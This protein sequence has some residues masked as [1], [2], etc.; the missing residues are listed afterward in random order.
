[1]G[2]PS[3]GDDPALGSRS[4]LRRRIITRS[5]AALG[6]PTYIAHRG[7]AVA[8][9]VR[10]GNKIPIVLLHS[11]S[12][13]SFPFAELIDALNGGGHA[14]IAVDFPGHG[15]SEDARDPGE[16]YSFPGYAAAV[17][18]V[19][20]VLG[21]VDCHLLGWSLGGHVAL[22]MMAASAKQGSAPWSDDGVLDQPPHVHGTLVCGTPPIRPSPEALIDAFSATPDM[23]F[24]GE[25]HLTPAQIDAYA[26]LLVAPCLSGDDMLRTMIAR[27]DGR[28][29]KN[30]MA[31]GLAGVGVDQVAALT[32]AP[33][34]VA[35]VHGAHDPFVCQQ[36]LN[37]LSG[38]FEDRVHVAAQAAHAPFIE[39][40]DL[41]LSLA[42]RYFAAAERR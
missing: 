19:L 2:A 13:S 40:P 35:V 41:F 29:R 33:F 30:M 26:E 14:V 12:A 24:A 6:A 4:D 21:V 5:T 36:Y 42:T 31:N 1:M 17:A 34:P 10:E 27:T 28:A 25:E 37:T 23:A 32:D 20:A 16:T 15:A 38:L 39:Q 8:A 11:N 3:P 9:F 7:R 22:E 18:R